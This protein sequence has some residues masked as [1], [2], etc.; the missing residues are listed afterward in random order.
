MHVGSCLMH[1]NELETGVW[2]M[3]CTQQRFIFSS[4]KIF[5]YIRKAIFYIYE[6]RVQ[7]RII[8]DNASLLNKMFY[9][10]VFNVGQMSSPVPSWY[11]NVYIGK[12]K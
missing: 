11:T 9:L 10:P 1:K 5:S 7:D 2:E 12:D 8:K 6:R 3:I 4:I